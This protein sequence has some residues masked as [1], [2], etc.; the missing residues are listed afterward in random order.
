MLSQSK[1]LEASLWLSDSLTGYPWMDLG[2]VVKRLFALDTL[3]KISMGKEKEHD[4]A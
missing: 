3:V 1:R 2:Y 4:Y